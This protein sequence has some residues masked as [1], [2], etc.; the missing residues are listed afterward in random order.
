MQNERWNIRYQEV[1]S[2]IE[3]QQ[4][5]SK[6]F[7][8][9]TAP[10]CDRLSNFLTTQQSKCQH[11]FAF[12]AR[13]FG[14]LRIFLYFRQQLIQIIGAFGCQLSMKCIA[15]YRIS[16]LALFARMGDP[17]GWGEGGRLGL[18][19]FMKRIFCGSLLPYVFMEG[20]RYS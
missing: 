8:A 20:F 10:K 2:F 5:E 12:A 6:L 16:S 18:Y 14:S 11:L 7:S 13:K 19:V 17:E 4:R 3:K 15:G 9:F 1:T